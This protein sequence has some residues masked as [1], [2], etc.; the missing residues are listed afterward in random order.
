VTGQ[1]PITL[2]KSNNIS[3]VDRKK[4]AEDTTDEG[5]EVGADDAAAV[6]LPNKIK[7]ND[8]TFDEK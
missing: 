1:I 5:G 8:T 7:N 6:R 3:K 2:F 4:R